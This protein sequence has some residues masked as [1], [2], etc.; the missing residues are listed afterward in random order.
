MIQGGNLKLTESRVLNLRIKIKVTETSTKDK[1]TVR[2]FMQKF[3]TGKTQ[4]VNDILQQTGNKTPVS[5]LQ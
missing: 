1:L 2:Q 3:N 4:K 5:K